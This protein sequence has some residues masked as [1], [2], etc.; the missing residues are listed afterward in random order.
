M[1][2]RGPRQTAQ[3]VHFSIGDAGIKLIFVCIFGIGLVS[4]G[5]Y[6]MAHQ[7]AAKSALWYTTE[8]N[9]KELGTQGMPMPIIGRFIPV[10]C[11]FATYTYTIN[12][13]SYTGEEKCG[14]CLS[15]IRIFSWKPPELAKRDPE[16][17][18]KE[19]E[20]DLRAAQ[21]TGDREAMKKV[22]QKHIESAILE[23][24]YAP[25]KA[26]YDKDHPE[27]SVLDPDVLQGE[28]SQLYTSLILMGLGG[29]LLGGTYMHA[30]VTAPTPDD[31]SLSLEAALKHQRRGGR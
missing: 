21:A 20:T 24:H 22:L 10:S 27:D 29:L 9:I 1:H 26:R 5:S 4:L 15:W 7:Q 25:V 2:G 12:G 16:E 3:D 13:K 17:F 28:K 30:F 14:P 31:P 23:I 8:A 18:K 19:L 6:F 11:P